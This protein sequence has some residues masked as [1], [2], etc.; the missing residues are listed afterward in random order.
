ML[1]G[2]VPVGES[3]LQ[4]DVP[5]LVDRACL[6]ENASPVASARSQ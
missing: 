4:A 6:A 3:V 2:C 1:L 5:Q